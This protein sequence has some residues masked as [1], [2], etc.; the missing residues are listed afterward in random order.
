VLCFTYR[1]HLAVK[2]QFSN[3]GRIVV[4]DTRGISVKLHTAGRFNLESVTC[5]YG[6]QS[7]KGFTAYVYRLVS[8][9]SSR[10]ATLKLKILEHY[11]V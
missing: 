11:Y 7:R 5:K 1:S 8:L 6:A 4:Y 2:T 9:I 3:S 10:Q